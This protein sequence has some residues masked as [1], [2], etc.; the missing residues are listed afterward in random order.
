[1]KSNAKSG[2][3]GALLGVAAVGLIPFEFKKDES[4]NLTYK[5]FLLGIN[6]EVD[7]QG[8]PTT[9]I[10]FLN[11]P[12]KEQITDLADKVTDKIN[13]VINDK[14]FKNKNTAVTVEFCDDDTAA[15]SAEP[16]A[17]TAPEETTIEIPVEEA[18]EN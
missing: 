11:K 1:M 6:K 15:E 18:P 2:L 17:E 13:D 5:S 8:E 12:E 14:F 16:D 3:I 4:G 9:T 10:T 7:E